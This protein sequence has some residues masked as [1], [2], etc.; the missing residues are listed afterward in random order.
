MT[1]K[2][3]DDFDAL[4]AQHISLSDRA[5]F[6]NA[7]LL[8]DWMIEK[9]IPI[10]PFLPEQIKTDRHNRPIISYGL[11]PYGYDISLGYKFKIF[12]ASRCAVVDPLNIDPKAFWDEEVDRPDNSD[13]IWASGPGEKLL[14]CSRCGQQVSHPNFAAKICPG[15]GRRHCDM[16][17]IMVPPNSMVLGEAIEWIE[18]PRDCMGLC[19]GKSTYARCGITNPITPIE[20][21]WKGRLTLEIANQ[22]PLPAKVYPGQGIAQILFFRALAE[23]KTAYNERPG[24]GKYQGAPGLQ[25]P[26]V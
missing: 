15:D 12:T 1:W 6:S 8:P 23:C 24:G 20:P 7:G 4:Y 10:K 14:T 19:I 13:H 21:G 9:H 5:F 22:N 16:P 11:G 25:L 18:M 17:F 2:P 26:R 3:G